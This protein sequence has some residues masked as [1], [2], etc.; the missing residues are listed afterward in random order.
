MSERQR[1]RIER[2]EQHEHGGERL[3][4]AEWHMS[5]EP[6]PVAEPGELLIIIKRYPDEDV[7]G[8]EPEEEQR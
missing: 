3:R 5:K 4:V 6:K 8:S 2:L 1:R 7:A